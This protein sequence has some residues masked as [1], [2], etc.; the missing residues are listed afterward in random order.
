MLGVPHASTAMNLRLLFCVLG[1]LGLCAASARAQMA[2][3]A[4]P[5]GPI[6]AGPYVVVDPG[7]T[8]LFL[9]ISNL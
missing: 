9:V 1:L 2:P 5:S 6:M 4:S 8:D 3:V 7:D